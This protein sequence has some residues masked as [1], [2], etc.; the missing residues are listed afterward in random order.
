M[1]SQETIEN[2]ISSVRKY[3]TI[4]ENYKKYT[5]S[6]IEESLDLRG[7]V[8]RYLYLAIQSTIDLAGAYISYRNYRKPTTMSDSFVILKER[9]V[10]P[11][12]IIKKM[13]LMTGLRN[14][15][16]HDYDELD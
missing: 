4:L 1:N 11:D 8:E 14:V 10:V 6:Q 9:K 3:L 12:E 2:K 16:T 7:A 13:I 5:R 15:I